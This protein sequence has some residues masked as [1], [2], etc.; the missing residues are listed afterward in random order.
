[1]ILHVT[2]FVLVYCE[3]SICDLTETEAEMMENCPCSGG[4]NTGELL[5]D[6][7]K[8]NCY[9]DLEYLSYFCCIMHYHV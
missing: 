9:Y 4:F 6:H 5:L 2:C 1:M 3:D 7:L 8:S